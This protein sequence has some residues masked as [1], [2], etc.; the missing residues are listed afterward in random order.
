[1][2]IFFKNI[3]IK[4]HTCLEVHGNRNWRMDFKERKYP[5]NVSF[6][7]LLRL[8]KSGKIIPPSFTH[9][10]SIVRDQFVPVR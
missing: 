9:P 1:M 7:D 8:E 3:F 10:S 5:I 2:F 4:E 6:C